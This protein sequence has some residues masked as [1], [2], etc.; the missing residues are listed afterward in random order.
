MASRILFLHKNSIWWTNYFELHSRCIICG[1]CVVSPFFVDVVALSI[2]TLVTTSRI[3]R[4]WSGG[5][6]CYKLSSC[7]NSRCQKINLCCTS[8]LDIQQINM[9]H[10]FR[11]LYRNGVK[12]WNC[13]YAWVSQPHFGQVWGWSPTLPKL[14]IWSPLG[15]P[16]V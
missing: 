6:S 4:L 1:I 10:G 3:I 8:I 15:L 11:Q 13:Y 16:N 9:C 14:G 2:A 7:V 5:L 12:F